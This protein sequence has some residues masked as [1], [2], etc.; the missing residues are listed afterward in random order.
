MFFPP[1]G[2][3]VNVDPFEEGLEI[4]KYYADIMRTISPSELEE[5]V[6]ASIKQMIPNYLLKAYPK[7]I[8]QSVQ[9]IKEDFAQSN[10]IAAGEL[11]Y[12]CIIYS[13]KINS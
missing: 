4:E 12:S 1:K 2:L 7:F 10:K 11:F 5:S 9:E 6:I 8:D 13:A 3:K